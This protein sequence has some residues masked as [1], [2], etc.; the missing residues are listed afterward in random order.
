MNNTQTTTATTSQSITEQVPV[1]TIVYSSFGWEQTDVTYYEVVRCTAKTVWLRELKQ[2][3]TEQF[4]WASWNVAPKPGEYAND[5]VL[6]RRIG[7]YGVRAESHF[8]WLWDGT[9]KFRSMWG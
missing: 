1:G 5:E 6:M 7:K 9:P 4:S 8:V 2:G 3:V